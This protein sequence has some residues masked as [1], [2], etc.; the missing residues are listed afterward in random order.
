MAN[1]VTASASAAET[2]RRG[3]A[4]DAAALCALFDALFLA[5]ENTRLVAGGEEPIYL[6]AGPEH[7]ESR[8]VFRHDYVSSALHEIAHWCIA[9]AARRRLVDYG[10]W[11]RPDGRDAACQREFERLEARPQALEWIFHE[12]CGLRF[13][14]SVDNLD[15]A[16]GDARGFAEAI[17]AAALAY[18]RSGLPP[19]AARFRAALAARFGDG[20]VPAAA[21]YLASRLCEDGAPACKRST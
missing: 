16:P 7:P 13:R 5:T 8:L 6:P 3:A 9:G 4:P 12:A 11:Y 18:C 20:T 2:A 17:A 19:R 15:G 10:Y 14:P 1:S 21:H